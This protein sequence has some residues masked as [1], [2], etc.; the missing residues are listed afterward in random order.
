MRT[1][2][3][4]DRCAGAVTRDD[5]NHPEPPPTRVGGA[6]ATGY[7]GLVK[8]IGPGILYAGAAIGA[9]HLV[10]STRAGAN[11][12]FALIWAVIAANLFKYPFFEFGTRYMAATGENLLQGYQRLGQ[13]ALRLYLGLSFCMAIT[14][15]AAVTAVTVGLAGNLFGTHLSPVAWAALVLA[16]CALVLGLGRYPWLD[17]LMKLIMVL[18]ALSTIMAVVVAARHGSS[19]KPDFAAPPVWNLAGITF[20]IALMGWMPTPVDASVWPSLWAVERSRQTG[21][22]PTMRQALFDFN[23]G[24]LSSSVIALF[25]LSLG[26]LVMF[27]TGESFSDSGVGFAGQL[28]GLYTKS[29]GAWSLLLISVAV[30]TTMLSTVLTVIDGYPRTLRACVELA[31]PRTKRFGH[32]LYWAF[33]LLL[34]GTSL[35]ILQ[36]LTSHMV[37]LVDVATI[38]SFLPAPILAYINYRVIRNKNVPPQAA[39]PR[40]LRVLSWLGLV[41]LSG[42]SIVFL[43]VRYII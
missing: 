6:P 9:S 26:A 22:K 18:L 42:F 21:H 14:S 27:G 34:C 32:Y 39:P 5:R 28:V 30:F 20:L 31:V 37:R 8:T 40:W 17:R 29:L 19:A 38:L 36:F 16:F 25:F 3:A 13:W 43:V 11:Y 10:Q 1:T 15:V 12:G 2:N 41:F 7:S 4:A 35:G 33:L 23:L 24:Y